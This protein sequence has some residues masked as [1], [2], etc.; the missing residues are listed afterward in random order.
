MYMY[1]GKRIIRHTRLCRGWDHFHRA[2][3]G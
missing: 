3:A 1:T 2:A